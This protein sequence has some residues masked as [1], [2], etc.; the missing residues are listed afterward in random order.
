MIEYPVRHWQLQ[1]FINVLPVI[2]VFI[3]TSLVHCLGD[4]LF[5]RAS[6]TFTW[7]DFLLGSFCYVI[8]I[9][10]WLWVLKN[11]KLSTLISMGTVLQ[12]VILTLVG[13]FFFKEHL[14][15]RETFGIILA[16]LAV[17]M[18]YKWPWWLWCSSTARLPVKEKV[19]DRH[20]LVTQNASE[21]LVD[22]H[23]PL[24]QDKRAQYPTE[25]P[26]LCCD[27]IKQIGML[28]LMISILGL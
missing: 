7:W 10:V 27:Y 16:I 19:R 18:F 13:V 2:V 6:I 22:D 14:S 20:P 17:L 1:Y 3:I 8:T 12:L 21:D 23:L 4:V 15:T 25:A 11:G 24:K 5:K 28:A 9:P 26:N